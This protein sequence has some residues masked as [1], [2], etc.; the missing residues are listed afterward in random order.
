MT[1][2]T[3]LADRM[4]RYAD[5][6]I[7]IMDDPRSPEWARIRCE[8]ALGFA[9][10]P[11]VSHEYSAAEIDVVPVPEDLREPYLERE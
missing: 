9:E 11:T 4:M 3:H 7:E 2:D 8:R 5:A 6:L 1:V 10:S